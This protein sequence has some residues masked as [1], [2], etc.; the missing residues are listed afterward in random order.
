MRQR[1]GLVVLSSFLSLSVIAAA[2]PKREP[3]PK[4]E[5]APAPARER[6]PAP[7]SGPRP[8]LV[9]TEIMFDPQSAETAEAQTEWVEVHNRGA[10]P[11][12]LRGLQITS[13]VKGRVHDARQKFVLPDVTLAA[14][15]YAV[16]GIGAPACYAELGLPAMAACCG[17]S[18]YAWFANT[19]DSVAIRDGKG[20]VIDE[21]VY[22]TESPWPAASRAGGS[23]QF[24]AP[25][26]AEDPT[27]ANDEPH[28]W[29]VSGAGNSRAFKDHGRGTPGAPPGSGDATTQ[30]VAAKQR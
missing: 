6:E 4:K 30:P 13:G 3:A 29:V 2:P 23:I 10:G 22:Q 27:K 9:I 20:N 5:P 11:A 21:V 17:E 26:D 15:E 25:P 1:V 8:S 16:I 12:S 7:Q 14:G 28:H 18:K 24:V 19:G